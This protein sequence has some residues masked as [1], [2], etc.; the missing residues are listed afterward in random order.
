MEISIHLERVSKAQS[1]GFS[2]LSHRAMGSILPGYVSE[3]KRNISRE[4]GTH[5]GSR[6]VVGKFTS[7]TFQ[8]P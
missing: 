5:S 7:H 4:D 2:I 6:N 1:S 8:N 3:R